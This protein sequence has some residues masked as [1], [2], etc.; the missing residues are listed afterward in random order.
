[1]N[2]QQSALWGRVPVRRQSGDTAACGQFG[3]NGRTGR[4]GRL[5]AAAASPSFSVVR[6]G[7]AV[8]ST[9]P[10]A[11][12]AHEDPNGAYDPRLLIVDDCMLYRE[13]LA[14]VFAK[15]G[16]TQASVAWDLPTLLIALTKNSPDLVLLNLDTR[17][18]STL[19]QAIFG[20]APNIRVIVMG[21]S[22]DDEAGI[23]ACAEAGVAGYHLRT[24]TLDDLMNLIRAVARG[25]STRSARISA[26]LLRRLSQLASRPSTAK[27]LVLTDRES[28]TLQMLQM[29]LSNQDIASRLGIAV[30]TVKN[31]VHN[32]LTKLGV[33]TRAEAAALSRTVLYAGGTSR[34]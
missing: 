25:E 17:D 21:V 12:T 13:N 28:Q 24:E 29:G 6:G 10:D 20:V 1:M 8:V 16:Y 5:G 19:L 23:I 11:F 18:A 3:Q 9:L 33:S 32:V 34:N 15:G 30:H 7:E 4:T 2:S 26:I 31:H 22:E 27:E 14:A